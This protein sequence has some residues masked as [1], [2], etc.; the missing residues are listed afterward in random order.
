MAS[1]PCKPHMDEGTRL[2]TVWGGA[3]V[4]IGEK[5]TTLEDPALVEGPASAVGGGEASDRW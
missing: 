3:Q 1:T 4:V 5:A 2:W